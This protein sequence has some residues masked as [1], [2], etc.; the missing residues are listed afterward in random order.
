[1][2]ASSSKT[3]DPY[4]PFPSLKGQ[5]V[6]FSSSS[7]FA[8]TY[9][10][11]HTPSNTTAYTSRIQG[12]QILLENP[13]RESRAKKLRD[14]KRARQAQDGARRKAGVLSR[15]DAKFTG[16]WKLDKSIAK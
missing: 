12:R 13:A 10:Q 9:V 1:M 3:L 4:K 6:S 5:K 2:A 8:P 15:K 7:P 16:A 14:A 11:S